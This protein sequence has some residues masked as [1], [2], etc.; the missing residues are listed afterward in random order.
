MRLYRSTLLAGVV[1]G[2]VLPV[3]AASAATGVAAAGSA[4]STATIATVGVG[5]L[6]AGA[7]TL[8][9]H[10]VSVGM[11][12]AGAQTVSTAAPAVTFTPVIV[13]GTKTGT[14]TVTPANSPKTVGAISTGA[15]PLNVLSATSPSATLT[16]S[17]NA[18]TR[19]ASIKT[20]LGTAKI[21]GLAV[22]LSGA[23][24]VGSVTDAA[25]S[26]AGKTL[27]ITNISLPSIASLLA[28]LGLDLTKLP[29][30]TLNGLLT[31]LPVTV[32]AAQQTAIDN[33]NV[34]VDSAQ[35]GY[36][37]AQTGVT[38]AEN[39]LA[40]K[41]ADLDS[42]LSGAVYPLTVP[43]PL[44]HAGWD[45]LSAGD[46]VLVENLNSG[47][48]T[49]A[50]DYD[51]AKQ[52]VIDA[53]SALAT[54]TTALAGAVA[55]LGALANTVLS[56]TPL[57]TIGAAEV[58]TTALV[59]ATKNAAVT[60]YVSGVKVLGQDVLA[61]VTGN[62][63]LDAAKLAGDVAS[64]VNSAMAT[65]TSTLS[66]VLSSATGATGLMVPAPSV[67]LLVK[68]AKTGVDGAFGTADAT[69]SALEV[70]MGS[71]TLPTAYAL[72]NAT[73]LAGIAPISTGFKTA[74]LSVKVGTL[75]ESA[76][77]R[78]GSSTTG[79]GAPLATTGMPAG[80]AVIALIGTGVAVVTRRRLRADQG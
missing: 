43:G 68:S 55:A 6:T 36:D 28:A 63:K 50:G 38:D 72:D 70:S 27:T 80:L 47:L 21:L 31:Q 45:A 4:S 60:G 15:L 52:G 46:K 62:S 67:K 14:V 26:Q 33:A 59:G 5:A 3:T 32:S 18:A 49:I 19:N 71:I 77:F 7:T 53:N 2:T 42:A 23:L 58:S 16:A 37:D 75:V 73:D 48:A 61:A 64:Q 12:D 65:L 79:T 17:Q 30:A 9:A 29:A 13:D 41:T 51:A 69:V 22:T 76:R 10:T 24:D 8:A 35:Q 39:T 25:H 78:N 11:L 20:S 66:S 40:S 54:A 74:P 34:A 56:G 57:V 1:L 44:D